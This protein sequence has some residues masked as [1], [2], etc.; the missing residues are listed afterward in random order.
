M[1]VSYFEDR[2]SLLERTW[3][4]ANDVVDAVVDAVVVDGVSAVAIRQRGCLV[5]SPDGRH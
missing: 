1:G 5:A 2:K 3:Q 4:A